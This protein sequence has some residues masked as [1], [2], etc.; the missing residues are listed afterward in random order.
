MSEVRT[1]GVFPH[2]SG[3]EGGFVVRTML[4]GTAAAPYLHAVPV[5]LPG[6]VAV[7]KREKTAQRCA[8]RLNEPRFGPAH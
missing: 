7:F 4:D 6:G 8:D 2:S 1:Y 3:P 5:R